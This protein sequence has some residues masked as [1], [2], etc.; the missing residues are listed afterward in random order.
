MDAELSNEIRVI[1]KLNKRAHDNVVE[2]FTHGD[3]SPVV[4]FIDMELCEGNLR[5]LVLVGKIPPK[6]M[7]W[8]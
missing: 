6:Y 8:G 3:L 1:N 2:I 4:Y 7:S 5:D